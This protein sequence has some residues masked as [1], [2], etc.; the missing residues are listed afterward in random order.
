MINTKQKRLYRLKNTVYN[1]CRF[2]LE[3]VNNSDNFLCLKKSQPWYYEKK[4][5]QQRRKKCVVCLLC[6]VYLASNVRKVP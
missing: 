1:A 2:W 3:K 5:E 6:T 4:A